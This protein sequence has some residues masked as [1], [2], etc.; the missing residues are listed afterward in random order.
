M[1]LDTA[2]NDITQAYGAVTEPAKAVAP[3]S[4]GQLQ[5]Q[6]VVMLDNCQSLPCATT[7]RIVV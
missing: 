5:S 6:D 2:T 1:S 4:P 7:A 3:L